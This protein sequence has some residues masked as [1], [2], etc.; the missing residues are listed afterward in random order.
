MAKNT[1]FSSYNLS[2]N[3]ISNEGIIHIARLL[4]ETTHIVSLNLQVN[5]IRDQGV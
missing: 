1:N 5:G 4:R 2:Y 3:F